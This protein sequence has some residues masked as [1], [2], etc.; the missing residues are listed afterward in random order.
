MA[1]LS[2]TTAWNETAGFVQ[3]EARLL[4]PLSFM[5]VALPVALLEALMPRAAP[6]QAPEAGAWMIVALVALLAS[7]A[8]N[9][10]LTQLALKPGAS[11][12]E[13]LRHALGRLLPMLAAVLLL[14]AA[15]VALLLAIA[16][17]IVL[18]VTGGAPAAD[19]G[20]PNE[21]M[22]RASLLMLVLIAP[23][24]I[25]FSARLMPM[26]PV[27]V[28]EPGGPFSIISRSWRLTRGH[29]LKLV[30][31]IL[32][33]GVLMSV[34]R[35]A[36]ESVLGSLLILAAGPAQPGSVSALLIIA[37][38]AA[39]NTVVAV[40]LATLIARIYAQLAA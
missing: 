7:L 39:V 35:I 16:F 24:L 2:I 8:G 27:A 33:I 10:A 36:I 19:P 5:L 15:G 6:G 13:A 4:F 25:Y 30:G 18:F 1:K 21:A 20:V 34:L 32:L 9:L 26:P 23:I 31:F 29:G 38:L 11:V 37:V 12:A 14:I 28:A 22:Q 3:R 40:Y 17:L